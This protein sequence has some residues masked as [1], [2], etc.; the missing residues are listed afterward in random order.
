M[1]LNIRYACMDK[2]IMGSRIDGRVSDSPFVLAS[3]HQSSNLSIPL[4][5]FGIVSR[6]T[7]IGFYM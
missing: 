2:V 3:E 1:D 4:L 7:F 6:L 5:V